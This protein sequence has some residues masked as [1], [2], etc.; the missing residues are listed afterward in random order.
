[1]ELKTLNEIESETPQLTS[2][3]D[4]KKVLRQEAINWIK[5]YQKFYDKSMENNNFK[6]YP[7]AGESMCAIEFIKHFFNITSENFNITKEN[8]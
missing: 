8:Y 2:D 3:N 7:N 5:H 6:S 4:F 1:M